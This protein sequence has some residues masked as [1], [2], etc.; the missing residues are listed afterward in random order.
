M[1]VTIISAV[2]QQA[3]RLVLSAVLLLQA[4]GY[5]ATAAVLANSLLIAAM[6]I[7]YAVY[8][9]LAESMQDDGR[10]K[11][12]RLFHHSSQYAAVMMI[13]VAGWGQGF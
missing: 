1:A 5:Y 4:F 8:P 12:V 7:F 9:R 2:A 10:Q 13:P 6:P 3:D 11:L